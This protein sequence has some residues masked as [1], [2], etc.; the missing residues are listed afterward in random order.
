[1]AVLYTA[2]LGSEMDLEEDKRRWV[3]FP[4]TRREMVRRCSG[5]LTSPTAFVLKGLYNLPTAYTSNQQMS[6]YDVD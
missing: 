4:F 5:H 2:G 3:S 6:T 1:M